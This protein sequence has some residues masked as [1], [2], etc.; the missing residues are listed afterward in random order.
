M[1]CLWNNDTINQQEI[2][3]VTIKDKASMTYLIDN[4]TKRGL[5][6]RLEDTN[7]RR[8]KLVLLTEEGKLLRTKIQPVMDEMH[9][10][11]GKNIDAAKLKEFMAVLDKIEE[12]LKG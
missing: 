6:T 9:E 2:A 7:D 8:N 1:Y 11:S 5:V 4:L 12:N 3:N 10:V